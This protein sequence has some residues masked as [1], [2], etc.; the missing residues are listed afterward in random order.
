MLRIVFLLLCLVGA[1][2]CGGTAPAA[3]AE[4]TI[5]VVDDAGHA[6]RLAAPAD[7]ILSLIPAR[8]DVLLALGAEDRLIARTRYD[9]DPRIAHLPSL[10]DAL[11]PSVEWI[12]ARQPDLV[13][14]WP[15]AQSRS[16]VQRLVE[17]G[18][19]V[20]ASRV[21][22]LDDTKR[23]IG[24][25]GELL[26]LEARADSVLRAI[27]LEH[28]RVR[29]AV[30]GRTRPDVL[31]LIG[32]DPVMAAGPGNFVDELIAIAGGR[33]VVDDTRAIWPQVSLEEVVRRD[34]AVIVVASAGARDDVVERLTA[35]AGWRE[36]TAV[37]TGRVYRVDP[38]LF[39]RPG[40]S[41][42]RA[43]SALA[44]ALHPGALAGDSL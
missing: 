10:G 34:P 24:H 33:N 14:A 18:I 30:A 20:Y 6:V 25:I 44:R 26:M 11:T 7:R 19:P 41:I 36:V 43:A 28:D 2:G 31:Y 29:A 40:P 12:T 39:N 17:L 8:T 1:A 5:E 42:G 9:E 4:A 35:R 16:V 3:R 38:S 15:D 37:R 13:I 23:A 32:L 21:E 22:T 27:Q